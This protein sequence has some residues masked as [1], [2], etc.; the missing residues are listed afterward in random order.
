MSTGYDELSV[1]YQKILSDYKLLEA[2]NAALK[3]R[4]SLYEPQNNPSPKLMS[5]EITTT[6]I[7]YKSAPDKK[8]ALFSSLFIARTDVF[9]TRWQNK[10]GKSGYT[11]ACQNEW[12]RGICKK[13]N[14]TCSRC[15]NKLYHTLNN[16][17]ISD[18]LSG[19]KKLLVFIH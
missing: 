18:H 14:V 4:L 6:L 17:V 7:D 2:E 10:Q 19:K 16:S 12:K 9:A 11:P 5:P 3:A 15:N 8:V 13:P 1:K